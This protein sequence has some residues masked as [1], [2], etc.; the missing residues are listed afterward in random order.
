MESFKNFFKKSEKPEPIPD[1]KKTI[2]QIVLEL[3]YPFETHYVETED[4]YILK[5]FRIN[6]RKGQN[7]HN[8]NFNL[9]NNII[10]F[11]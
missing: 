9:I 6:G 10:I 3:L 1:E 8:G 2:E 5:I 11:C 7:L 4:G